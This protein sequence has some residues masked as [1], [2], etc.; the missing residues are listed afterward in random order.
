MEDQYSKS[1]KKV[2]AVFEKLIKRKAERF[3]YAAIPDFNFE[4]TLMK[5]AKN[6]LAREFYNRLVEWINDFDS[7][8]DQGREVGV[9]LVTFGKAVVFHLTDIVYKNQSLISFIVVTEKQEPIELIQH[10]SQ[11]SV[12]LM[13][14]KRI[15]LNEPKKKIGFTKHDDNTTDNTHE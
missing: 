3:S 15:N 1:I 8:L 7:K 5:T 11:I 4:N 6:S 2:N 10:V 12:L 13:K 14:M 9:R